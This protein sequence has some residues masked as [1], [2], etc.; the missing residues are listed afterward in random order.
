[1]RW[2]G[3]LTAIVAL[4]VA[5][6]YALH[7][8]F[9]FDN[10][11]PAYGRIA[12][13]I[14][15]GTFELAPHPFSNRFAVTVPTALIYSFGI[16]RYTTTLWPLLVSVFSVVLV[17]AALRRP[18]GDGAA[19]W[20]AFLLAVNVVQFRYSSRLV[21][22]GFVAAFLLGGVAAAH[23]ARRAGAGEA[24]L[25][26]LTA[27]SVFCG[28]LAKGT[29]VWGVPFFLGLLVIDL[30][31]GRHRRFW[32]AA[33]TT[34][35]LLGAAFLGAY[36]A[37]TGNPFFRLDGIEDTH[38][39]AP[40][41]FADRETIEYVRRVT[42]EPLLFLFENPGYGLL[43][44]FSLPALVDVFVRLPFV[45]A[46]TRYWSLYL[47][48]VLGFFWVGTTSPS[49]YNPLPIGERFL[50]PMLAPMAIL[51]GITISALI[52]SGEAGGKR[53]A[54]WILGA[55]FALGFALLWRDGIKRALLYGLFVALVPLLRA[56]WL[57]APWRR[58]A[59]VSVFL[60][61]AG[62]ALLRAEQ[63]RPYFYDEAA[64]LEAQLRPGEPTVVLTDGHSAFVLPFYL[65][66][67]ARRDV[68]LADWKWTE[69]IDAPGR[70][71]VYVHEP[72]LMAYYRHWGGGRP[73]F[74]DDP[75]T[76]WQLVAREVLIADL[77]MTVFE[78]GGLED[79][80][81]NR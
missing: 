11:A 29:V 56:P 40:W 2:L 62:Y 52:G 69:G 5:L 70:V 53:A 31:R 13:E 19:L 22:D 21:P 24:R 80:S 8:N 74:V 79:L 72:R 41:S 50:I 76:D 68:R 6:S 23:R 46:G 51:A 28:L 58:A 47:A 43:F 20:A 1:V 57:G 36:A 66:E 64:F 9:D 30:R 49:S 44:V 33:V 27:A 18:F 10:D 71:L 77:G 78:L 48:V 25:G 73:A 15:A 37:A 59:G 61:V 17:F 3:T 55:A 7:G 4:H 32:A 14:Q 45:P 42:Y 38:N 81:F 63:P 35:V 54:A 26:V 12:A 67:R 34:G 65:G 16:D 75:P 60:I 39:S